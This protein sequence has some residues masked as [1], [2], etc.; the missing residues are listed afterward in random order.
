MKAQQLIRNS[1]V[2]IFFK[3]CNELWGGRREEGR[4]EEGGEEGPREYRHTASTDTHN[5]F[6]YRHTTSCVPTYFGTP[7]LIN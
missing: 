5:D 4:E 2:D 1:S 6:A 3:K 7:T